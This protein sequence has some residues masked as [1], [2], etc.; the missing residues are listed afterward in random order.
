MSESQRKLEFAQNN[1][2]EIKKT[3]KDARLAL[4]DA[5][6][7]LDGREQSSDFDMQK[8]QAQQETLRLSSP[9]GIS[10]IYSMSS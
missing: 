10:V 8:V 4:E 1:H 7:K 5:M 6:S 3:V 2:V 9:F